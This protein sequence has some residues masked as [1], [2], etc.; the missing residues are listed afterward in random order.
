MV[1][2]L[3][4]PKAR[5]VA[6][7][8]G[9][10]RVPMAA[11]AGGWWNVAVESAGPGTDY[12]FSLDGGPPLPDPRSPWQPHG[13]HGPSRVLEHQVFAWADGRGRQAGMCGGRPGALGWGS[14]H[15]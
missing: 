10:T 1:F 5:T 4:A 7:A 3:W 6:L 15:T 8:V 9:G 11:R 2:Q 13:V 14:G 12:A